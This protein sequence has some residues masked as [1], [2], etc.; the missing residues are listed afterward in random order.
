MRVLALT[1][2][3]TSALV[4]A[5]PVANNGLVSLEARA[6][7]YAV[8]LTS[9]KHGVSLPQVQSKCITAANAMLRPTML[10]ATTVGAKTL[11]LELISYSHLS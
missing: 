11:F 10:L 7:E 2:L 1:L 6:P 9:R 3:A 4:A 8:A 5:A